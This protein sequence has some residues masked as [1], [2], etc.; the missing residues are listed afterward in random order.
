MVVS[1]KQIV[2]CQKHHMCMRSLAHLNQQSQSYSPGSTRFYLFQTVLNKFWCHYS[3]GTIQS[4]LWIFHGYCPQGLF[5]LQSS[6]PIP[7]PHF[8]SGNHGTR[9]SS[10]PFGSSSSFYSVI[11]IGSGIAGF[12]AL[13]T[14]PISDELK[15]EFQT[16]VTHHSCS[17]LWTLKWTKHVLRLRAASYDLIYRRCGGSAWL[18]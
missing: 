16:L 6:A 7:T 14:S 11:M 4:W 2:G 1:C 10:T 15:A 8:G 17:L 18:A 13:K 12:V 3:P 5:S 9:T